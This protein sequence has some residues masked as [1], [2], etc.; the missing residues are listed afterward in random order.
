MNPQSNSK[1]RSHALTLT[2]TRS[3]FLAYPP[4]SVSKPERKRRRTIQAQDPKNL[5]SRIAPPPRTLNPHIGVNTTMIFDL[6]FAFRSLGKSPGFTLTVILTL[7]L[8]IGANTAIFSFFNGIL[9]R[10]LP[11][12]DAERT[13][14]V[15]RGVRNFGDIMGEGTGL[16]S[17]DYLDL[18][19]QARSFSGLTAYTSDVATL[20][21]RGAPE[22]IYG[23]VVPA[24]FFAVLGS[25]AAVG[26]VFS[27]SQSDRLVVLSYALWQNQFGG[28]PTI[29][30]QSITLNGSAFTMT[31]VMP[32][33][34][35]MPRSVLFCARTPTSF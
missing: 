10:P 32:A 19:A 29:I 7:A 2:P 9:L 14:M 18:Q 34:F 13:V 21:G 5:D 12:A 31:G 23:A 22:L 28:S 17:A 24:N 35:N 27:A 15:K 6:R 8:G 3:L 33:D 25:T 1:Y 16:L 30:G 20:S 11:Y 26:Q 4:N